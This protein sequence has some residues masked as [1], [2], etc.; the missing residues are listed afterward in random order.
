MKKMFFLSILSLMILMFISCS[1]INNKQNT[2][3]KDNV[4]ITM[5]ETT[6]TPSIT[7][8][9]TSELYVSLYP[10]ENTI[11]GN[12]DAEDVNVFKDTFAENNLPSFNYGTFK[13]WS[14]AD[15]MD[16]F[17]YTDISEKEIVDYIEKVKKEGFN[18]LS[19][20]D[21][22]KSAGEL[23][24]TGENKDGLIVE[25]RLIQRE[26]RVAIGFEDDSH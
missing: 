21:E 15:T 11:V 9:I 1:S 20:T 8:K 14:A 19:Y 26:V 23:T 13:E 22:Y 24:F 17:F 12:D 6:V 3:S 18:Q 7:S 25:I 4:P 5:G 10:E 2:D 16:Y